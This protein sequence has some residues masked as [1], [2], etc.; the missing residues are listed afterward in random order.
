MN[1]KTALKNLIAAEGGTATK[2]SI[3]GLLGELSETLEGDSD[4]KTIADQIQNIAVAKGY[5]DNED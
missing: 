2:T 4:G 1:I 5:G 3:K